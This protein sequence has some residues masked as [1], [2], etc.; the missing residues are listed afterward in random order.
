[1]NPIGEFSEIGG[2][3]THF[4]RAG[5]GKPVVL[6]HGSGPGVS[7]WENWNGIMPSLSQTH[8]VFAP[9]IVGFGRTE[10]PDTLDL[11][12]KIW[13]AH[14]IAFLDAMEIEKAVL[15]GNSFGGGLSL[16]ASLKHS[17]RIAAMILMGTPSGEFEQSAALASGYAFD[18]SLENM[19]ETLRKFPFD[20]SLVTDKMIEDRHALSLTHV[21]NAAFRKLMP[22]PSEDGA[23]KT[24][25]GVPLEQL[26]RIEAPVLLLHGVNDQVIPAAVSFRAQQHL[27]NSDL[28]LFGR[29]GHWVQIEQ[30][31][32]F[33]AE[34]DSFLRRMEW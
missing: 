18:P 6:L 33:L 13:V 32:Q 28:H 30:R 14:L 8:S 22:K 5:M 10:L 19:A 17:E 31:D 4:H 26:A 3:K 1:M 27:P 34:V 25:R 29:C 12:I 9:D 2:F 11:N 20:P 24:V 16:A 7:A 21:G 15:V 23:T